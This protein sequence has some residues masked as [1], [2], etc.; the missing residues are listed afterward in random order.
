MLLNFLRY[1]LFFSF[2]KFHDFMSLRC[3]LSFLN[4]P[5]FSSVCNCLY[6]SL[7]ASIFLLFPS[8]HIYCYFHSL[9][10]ADSPFPTFIFL[11]SLI[12]R[13]FSSIPAGSF[14][15]FISRSQFLLFFV[16][17]VSIR[18]LS[19]PVQFP[20]RFESCQTLLLLQ[21][22]LLRF[23]PTFYSWNKNNSQFKG[24]SKI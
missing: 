21:L 10:I 9:R 13:F 6:V 3:P 17:Y 11:A 8:F 2:L 1:Y 5:R 7:C 23:N 20:K 18:D 15:F 4:L 14:Q 16:S 19:C 12:F 24:L 22:S